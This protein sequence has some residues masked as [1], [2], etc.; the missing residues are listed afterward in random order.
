MRDGE[1]VFP[2]C[3]ECRYWASSCCAAFPSHVTERAVLAR[4]W[5]LFFPRGRRTCLFAVQTKGRRKTVWRLEGSITIRLGFCPCAIPLGRT[6]VGRP[7][8]QKEKM[9][10]SYSAC[11]V[12]GIGALY[13]ALFSLS[14]SIRKGSDGREMRQL[15]P[16]SMLTLVWLLG[17]RF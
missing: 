11:V 15:S 1:N 16:I 9:E 10:P 2:E 6:L 13:T 12:R 3:I 5:R 14:L 4:Q 8:N 7:R 17:K